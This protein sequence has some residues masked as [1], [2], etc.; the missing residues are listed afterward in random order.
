MQIP[1]VQTEPDY[2]NLATA[3]QVGFR[4]ILSV[5]L[6]HDGQA[7]GTLGVACEAPGQFPAA[8]VTLLETFARQAVIAIENVRLFN[9]T[10]EAL[11][12]QT[13]IAEIL[14]PLPAG[15]LSGPGASGIPLPTFCR[16]RRGP[17]Y[18]CANSF[19]GNRRSRGS[20][21]L[22]RCRRNTGATDHMDSINT[23]LRHANDVQSDCK[24]VFYSLYWLYCTY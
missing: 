2:N 10:K 6:L 18:A 14:R 17:R 22:A 9:E 23:G 24:T 5:P 21:H 4:S 11:E 1:D 8:A 3:Q 12:Q 13:S 19:S 7:I 16:G 15:T 20:R